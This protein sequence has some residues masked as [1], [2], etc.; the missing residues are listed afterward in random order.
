MEHLIGDL[1]AFYSLTIKFRNHIRNMADQVILLAAGLCNLKK[2]LYYS[3]GYKS[4][5]GTTLISM[6]DL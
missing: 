5:L 4:N 3:I 2:R 1:K 6:A